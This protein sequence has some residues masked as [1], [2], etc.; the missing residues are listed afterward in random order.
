MRGNVASIPYFVAL[1]LLMYTIELVAN[2][3]RNK[4]NLAVQPCRISGGTSTVKRCQF[5]LLG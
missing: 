2:L 3:E 4:K 5:H 1:K